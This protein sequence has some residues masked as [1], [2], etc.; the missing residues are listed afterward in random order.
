DSHCL[1]IGL[2]QWVGRQLPFRRTLEDVRQKG[3]LVFIAHPDGQHRLFFR[4]ADHRW[5]RVD[6]SG[7][8]GIEVWSL[9]FDWAKQTNPFNLPIRYFRFPGNLSGPSPEAL[10]LWDR[11]AAREHV[12]GVA[13]LDIH[14][15]PC[16]SLDIAR[17]FRYRTAFLI[18]RNHLLINQ[19]LIRQRE[20]DRELIL[21]A[22]TR[23][24][25]FFARDDLKK[26]QGFFFG[27]EDG[28]VMMG[29]WTVPGTRVLIKVPFLSSIR[30]VYNGTLLQEKEK[31]EWRTCLEKPGVYRVEVFLGKQ[32]WIFSNHIYVS[33]KKC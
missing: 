29:E 17:K 4:K 28:Q 11:K 14:S 8:D 24:R 10:N 18:L 21:A 12:T 9:L 6:I 31:V 1:A 32:P 26:S 2:K 16:P 30:L 20:I 27:C 33:D 25:L 22:L 7:Y 13:G 23:G 15:L 3:G 19:P 5:K